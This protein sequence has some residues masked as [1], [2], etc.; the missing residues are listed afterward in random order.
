MGQAKQYQME[1]EDKRR[2]AEEVAE[3]AGYLSKC[4]IHDEYYDECA[5]DIN[6][7]YKMAASLIKNKD[8][9]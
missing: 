1:Q 8:H 6:E 4:E 2:I 3:R 5:V 9:F 7:T